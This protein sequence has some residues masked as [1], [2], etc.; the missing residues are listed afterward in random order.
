[1]FDIALYVVNQLISLYG[2]IMLIY[3]LCSWLIRDP[4][5][6]FMQ[7]LAMITEPALKPIKKLLWR[8]EFFRR[9]PV[10]FS[11]LV[12]F[13]ILRVLVSLLGRLSYYV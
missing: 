3:C 1:M 10:D 9:S 11:P 12:L 4:S 8:I 6:K 5:N 2:A 13:L 7:I